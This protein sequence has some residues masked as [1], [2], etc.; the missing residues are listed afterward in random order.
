VVVI[1]ATDGRA[2]ANGVKVTV[3][4]ARGVRVIGNVEVMTSCVGVDI[5]SSLGVELQPVYRRI[6]TVKITLENRIG[7]GRF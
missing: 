5:G 7:T 2:A 3:A 4:E 1:P 6:K